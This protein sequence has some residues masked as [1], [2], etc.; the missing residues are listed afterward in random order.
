MKIAQLQTSALD[1]LAAMLKATTGGMTLPSEQRAAIQEQLSIMI[2]EHKSSAVKA[3]AIDIKALLN[4]SN[5]L[6]APM[7]DA[8]ILDE[9]VT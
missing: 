8:I 3:R 9:I 6:D 5:S 2:A 1:S 4:D 7:N